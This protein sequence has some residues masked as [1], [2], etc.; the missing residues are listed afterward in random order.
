MSGF[1]WMRLKQ[2]HLNLNKLLNK[3]SSQIF[4]TL[5]DNL[6]TTEKWLASLAYC[7][8]QHDFKKVG[9]PIC[10]VMIFPKCPLLFSP[11]NK[12]MI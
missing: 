9:K 4:K 11:K 5:K 2:F 6:A 10:N 12:P 8:S 3:M 7:K 1:I